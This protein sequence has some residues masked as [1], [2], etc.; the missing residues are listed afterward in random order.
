M[1]NHYANG[2]QIA[3]NEPCLNCTCN[4][5]M[6]MCYLRVCPFVRPVDEDCIVEKEEGECCPKI[7]C[8]EG[9]YLNGQYYQEGAQL[10]P[11]EDRPCE[12]CYCILNST[13]CVMQECA[14]Q[15]EG[16]SPVYQKGACCPSRYNCTKNSATTAPPPIMEE[17]ESEGCMV[18]NQFFPD[19]EPVETDDPCEHCYCM[20]NEVV[21]A[22][23]TCKPPG[24]ACIPIPDQ[25]NK[26]CPEKY[27]CPTTDIPIIT[28]TEMDN[29]TKDDVI[30]TEISELV[31]S[32]QTLSEPTYTVHID[33][34]KTTLGQA[35]SEENITTTPH[36]VLEEEFI[37]TATL[38]KHLAIK[39]IPEKEESMSGKEITTVTEK[40]V[41]VTSGTKTPG[42][43]TTETF[44]LFAGEKVDVTVKPKFPGKEEELTSGQEITTV[45]EE[46]VPVTKTTEKLTTTQH[47]VI[48]KPTSNTRHVI[49]PA[50]I[51]GEV[52]ETVTTEQ[53]KQ[54]ETTTKPENTHIVTRLDIAD[55]IL[56]KQTPTQTSRIGEKST[57]QTLS[58]EREITTPAVE[59]GFEITTQTAEVEKEITKLISEVGEEATTQTVQAER[60]TTQQSTGYD[61]IIITKAVQI[62]KETTPP[63]LEVGK[64]NTSVTEVKKT[65]THTAE[66]ENEITEVVEIT[67]DVAQ[68][69]K[70][71]TTQA[72]RID[73]E[74][75]TL[76]TDFKVKTITQANQVEKEITNPVTEIE[77]KTTQTVLVEKET[78]TS[79]T[80]YGEEMKTPAVEVEKESTAATFQEIVEITTQIS[81]FE[82]E[83][84][85]QSS[86]VNKETTTQT[87]QVEKENAEI[88]TQV[89]KLEKET[90][91]QNSQV[92]KESTTSDVEFVEKVTTQTV[93]S[94][95]E[96]TLPSLDVE[97]NTTSETAVT[98][99]ITQTFEHNK[100]TITPAFE[101]DAEITTQVSKLEK[102][103]T[104]TATDAGVKTITQAN[105]VE[106]KTTTQTS[107]VEKETTTP[108]V[109]FVEKVTTQTVQSEKET[110][111]LYLEVKRNTT[112]ETA[113][114]KT[115]TQTFEHN[116]ETIT[117]AFEEDAEIT[118][119]V[120]KLEKETTTTATDAG[121]KTITQANQV[122]KKTTT[123]TSQVEKETTT[124][125]VEFETIT[126][127]FEED[128]EI[129][130]QV[131]K[132]E[133][134]TTTT[135][136]DA[137][138][139]TITQANQVEEKTTTQTSQVEKETT[140][141]DVEFVE[142]VTTQ[143]V[144]SE[145]ET[146]LPS[147]EVERNTTS[148]TAVNKTITQI[149][150]VEKESVTPVTEVGLKITTKTGETENEFRISTSDVED[151]ITT[152]TV[153]VEKNATIPST[154]VVKEYTTLDDVID[155]DTTKPTDE[156]DKAT[157][158]TTTIEIEKELTSPTFKTD[159]DNKSPNF[160][161]VMEVTTT[162]IGAEKENFIAT[163]EIDKEITMPPVEV[164]KKSTAS[165]VAINKESITPTTEIE[166]EIKTTTQESKTTFDVGTTKTP[167]VHVV[168]E[169]TTQTINIYK[170]P[171]TPPVEIDSTKIPVVD[172]D[173]EITTLIKS[174]ADT[175]NE[176]TIKPATGVENTETPSVEVEDTTTE[177]L[178]VRN[179]ATPHVNIEETSKLSVEV[180]ELT[181]KGIIAGK[182]T[183]TSTTGVEKTT[184][185]SVQVEE[186][187]VLDKTSSSMGEIQNETSTVEV[188]KLSLGTEN[189]VTV[190]P[191]EKHFSTPSLE[192]Q[193]PTVTFKNEINDSTTVL[194]SVL[195]SSEILGWLYGFAP[196]AMTTSKPSEETG[197]QQAN[198]DLSTENPT[199][200]NVTYTTTITSLNTQKEHLP[201]KQFGTLITEATLGVDNEI[202]L[203]EM[204]S[205]KQEDVTT[206]EFPHISTQAIM[207]TPKSAYTATDENETSLKNVS[208]T[209]NEE[210][211]TPEDTNSVTKKKGITPK[212]AYPVTEIIPTLKDV[213]T[214]T[215]E[216]V[217]IPKNSNT[218]IAEGIATLE[219]D[220]SFEETYTENVDGF[221]Q[222]ED[223]IFPEKLLSKH[224]ENTDPFTS[225]PT[226]TMSPTAETFTR[227]DWTTYI[228]GPYETSTERDP[229]E[230]NISLTTEASPDEITSEA[231]NK[232]NEW[233]NY[234]PVKVGTARPSIVGESLVI[235]TSNSTEHPVTTTDAITTEKRIYSVTEMEK[236]ST[237]LTNEWSEK[238][239]STKNPS[240]E[241]LMT[242]THTRLEVTYLHS[243]EPPVPESINLVHTRTTESDNQTDNYTN[244]TIFD[245]P[246]TEQS[247]TTAT[248][249]RLPTV[250][251]KSVVSNSTTFSSD[252]TFQEMHEEA[253]K[254]TKFS[255]AI[256]DPITESTLD[257]KTTKVTKDSYEKKNESFDM[258]TVAS[259]DTTGTSGSL[260]RTEAVQDSTPKSEVSS[261][262][263][264]ESDTFHNDEHT[265]TYV[266]LINLTKESFEV[267]TKKIPMTTAEWI[268]EETNVKG[269]REDFSNYKITPESHEIKTWI[270]TISGETDVEIDLSTGTTNLEKEEGTTLFSTSRTREIQGETTTNSPENTTLTSTLTIKD[271]TLQDKTETK[272]SE[273]TTSSVNQKEK[274]EGIFTSG[275]TASSGI[276]ET[277]MYFTSALREKDVQE[278]T[279][280]SNSE[281]STSSVQE[282]DKTENK[283]T[284]DTTIFMVSDEER[285]LS[286]TSSAKDENLQ[287]KSEAE[288]LKV[289]TSSLGQMEEVE[290]KVTSGTTTS[291]YLKE[292]T[293]SSTPATKDKYLQDRTEANVSKV[294]TSSVGQPEKVEGE[295]TSGTTMSFGVKDTTLSSNSATMD[296]DRQDIT[297]TTVPD[298]TSGFVQTE[299]VE[300]KVISG[301]NTSFEIEETTLFSTSDT[302]DQDLQDIS[303]ATVS[304]MT[305]NSVHSEKVEDKLT[306]RTNTSFEIEDTTL[307]SISATKD[308][309]VQDI[310][311]A[312]VSE[313]T[314]SSVHTE[315]VED[316][317]TSRTSTSFEIEEATL[318]STPATKDQNL[319]DRTEATVSEVTD[320]SVKQ[321]DKVGGKVISGTNTSFEIEETTLFSTSDTKDQDLQDISEATVS[322][323][324]TSSVET[325]KV[326]EKVTSGTNTTFEIEETTLSSTSTTK[327]QDFPDIT[328]ATVSEMTTSSVHTEK[329]E[330][331]VTSVN[332]SSFESEETT[333]FSTSATK[334]QDV[335]DITEAA[336]SEMT[337]SSVQTEKV[338]DKVTSGTNTTFE[339]EETTLSSTPATQD[340]NLQDRTE[341][342]FSEVTDISV[343]QTDKVGGKVISGTNTPIAFEETILTST[344]A[345]KDQD[346]QDRTEATV[347]EVSTSSII[348][349]NQIGGKVTSVNI[350]SFENE[351]TTLSST[352]ATKNQ[353]IQHRTE[354]ERS[355]GTTVSVKEIEEVEGKVTSGTNA[356]FEVEETTLSSISATKDEN[357]QDRFGGGILDI[358][359]S[360]GN[361]EEEL[362]LTTFSS[363]D[364]DNV[365]SSLS[366][367]KKN[368]AFRET[369]ETRYLERTN[370]NISI[371]DIYDV[372][373]S[374]NLQDTIKISTVTESTENHDTIISR[375][376]TTENPFP[377]GNTSKE[378]GNIESTTASYVAVKTT[379]RQPVQPTLFP[380]F[381]LVIS[382]GACVFDGRIYQSAEQIQR[383]DACEFC[384][385]FHGDILCIKQTCPPPRVGCKKVPI[386]GYCCPRYECPVK[387]MSMTTTSNTPIPTRSRLRKILK[388]SVEV[389]GCQVNKE[390]YRVGK[391]V[392]SLSNPCMRCQCGEVGLLTCDPQP[393]KPKPPLLLQLNKRFFTSL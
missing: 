299:K 25:E 95:K 296:Q 140:T 9:C 144:Q 80:E 155:R 259:K 309:D 265:Q 77:E 8:P 254:T 344:S 191:V 279:Q 131:S 136:T 230:D 169:T 319:Q 255:E 303:E 205:V 187:T 104:T 74:T 119:Q 242:Q 219:E 382:E 213:K 360:S 163:A 132:L 266:P 117:P 325:E 326:E 295:I 270:T 175:V 200:S 62:E 83:T 91:T 334:G 211:T 2:E 260:D 226:S 301:T 13:A 162:S 271:E 281:V 384:F 126:P 16:C 264:M 371:A 380:G 54:V 234:F 21:C 148:E 312:I 32:E 320:I 179:E 27:D 318:S 59:I 261:T 171:T 69:E 212:G 6:L 154:D 1:L 174:H 180:E 85:S 115:I 239:L 86:V 337:T 198:K 134:E 383:P 333:Q 195:T 164:N 145:K 110:T 237:T 206:S 197:H 388:R 332:S 330:G 297:E 111:A 368:Q 196:G 300:E 356:S 366:L 26:C 370:S 181:V 217:T 135:A 257:S 350:S 392:T 40:H 182:Q 386:S 321:T 150:E 381:P 103:T 99:T 393:C 284:S 75:P 137:G 178:T 57:A 157:T 67:S 328:E 323:V 252:V 105:Q 66:V 88:M 53:I 225:T 158:V 151:I 186:T 44:T 109:E 17:K 42:I 167:T 322:E 315:K 159:K 248:E 244:I 168:K 215:E 39:L 352:S 43:P 250:P 305:T 106:K 201:D 207:T 367:D 114:N 276:E 251:A 272:V 19:G 188:T 12:V 228:T 327:N 128:A 342:I 317:V 363:T 329:V 375:L 193:E 82:K 141:S 231:S 142:K 192:Q 73:K 310:T 233:T 241:T 101:E 113:V 10:P 184:T 287:N 308:E 31:P 204:Y 81:Q 267:T 210:L 288:T 122:E 349:T 79:S 324:T 129:T 93:Q 45:I 78:T 100:E 112:S 146:T 177:I 70:E 286:L 341:A 33:S 379:T 76:V 176:E 11:T 28:T 346:L 173:K 293:F 3:T 46:R 229:T 118:T 253:A 359:N 247:N 68:F 268:F 358:T 22:I 61:E 149:F 364:F 98:K 236:P 311:E 374:G 50:G 227:K 55:S 124:P 285:P 232:T 30:N 373:V 273:V 209:I 347:S 340:Q 4:N 246:T 127:A 87:S 190:K 92:E 214:V 389:Q 289:K 256:S 202:I 369:N 203:T 72:L 378:A 362:T 298:M 38:P 24:S 37:T 387:M 307:S 152:Q 338:Q 94:E 223:H 199:E 222:K 224:S 5:S 18:E 20:G 183:I 282:T 263:F 170:E 269:N 218:V 372:S 235:D 41:P 189:T 302:K 14:L 116:K 290:G 243:T 355:E 120:S 238:L 130:T 15:V 245:E 107:Q 23:Q 52:R 97:R 147:L 71:T 138:V 275:T 385:C 185:S 353:N 361:I 84:K 89:Y 7:T 36:T 314:T 220:T 294:I 165:D 335:Q 283:V 133:K 161:F 56:Q 316:K 47:P 102:E 194:A 376:S 343:N 377:V 121:V 365:T 249:L 35:T 339:I 58:V 139:K 278:I 354:S 336:V 277:T 156:V 160:E 262:K 390:F 313:M 172:V 208:T 96:T 240:T 348:K 34:D 331:K 258:T 166:R 143:T 29:I 108:D 216:D 291:V 391:T 304:E 274:S 345:T 125:D 123:Q 64:K 90:T 48:V 306:S 280:N 63:T 357:L 351:E 60:E 153:E 65:T 51:P 221:M 292:T 49:I